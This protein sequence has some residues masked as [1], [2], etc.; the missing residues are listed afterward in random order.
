MDEEI[1]GIREFGRALRGGLK[2]GVKKVVVDGVVNERW[3]AKVFS[4]FD[5]YRTHIVLGTIDISIP[6]M[7]I[8][9]NISPD[10]WQNYKEA[11][12][13]ARRYWL[14]WRYTRGARCLQNSIFGDRR[15]EDSSID[16]I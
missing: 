6:K 8:I 14:F 12:D 11:R 3:I 1:H 9:T 4:P 15:R 13:G 7:S 16:D 5:I 10:G 2:E